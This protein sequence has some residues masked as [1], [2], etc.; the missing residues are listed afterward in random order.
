MGAANTQMG[1][2]RAA[3]QGARVQFLGQFVIYIYVYAY[4]YIH[5]YYDPRVRY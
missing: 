1:T 2:L 5:M 4:I 3:F